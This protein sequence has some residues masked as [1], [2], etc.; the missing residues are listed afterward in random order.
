[1]PIGNAVRRGSVI[2]VYDDKGRALFTTSAGN[3]SKGDG[4]KGYT[5]GT[6]NVQR[7]STIYTYN[8]KG[9]SVSTTSAR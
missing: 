5:S 3:P 1:M 7:G 2:Y 4:L 6:V 8:E 9:R